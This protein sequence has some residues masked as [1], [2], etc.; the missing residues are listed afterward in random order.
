MTTREQKFIFTFPI[1]FMFAGYIASIL[2][3]PPW[4]DGEGWIVFLVEVAACL[5]PSFGFLYAARK[6]SEV[7]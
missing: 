1:L 2:T 5:G 6:L 3:C 4:H 7:R